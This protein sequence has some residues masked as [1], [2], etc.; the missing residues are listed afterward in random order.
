[1]GLYREFPLEN[2]VPI[3]GG[4]GVGD[5]WKISVNTMRETPGAEKLGEPRPH[6]F[7]YLKRA[8]IPKGMLEYL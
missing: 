1:M 7:S 2:T 6:H 5:I 3:A 8:L 4:P